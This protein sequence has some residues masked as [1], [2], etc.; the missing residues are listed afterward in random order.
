MADF[1]EERIFTFVSYGFRGGPSYDTDVSRNRVFT[2]RNANRDEPI[3]T[4]SAPYDLISVD[5][6]EDEIRDF[7]HPA[8]GRK[9]GFRFRDHKDFEFVNQQIAVGDDTT[10]QYQS[11]KTWTRGAFTTTKTIKKTNNASTKLPDDPA[12][13]ISIDAVPIASPDAAMDTTT[14]IITLAG[15]LGVG[16]VLTIDS[17][18]YD[19]P[20]FFASDF[21]PFDYA[22]FQG[23][24]STLELEEDLNA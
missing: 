11:I 12:L 2:N 6:F 20:V 14:G 7:F 21:N 5:D 13:V 8:K 4:Y 1:I 10:N 15:N 23:G 16:E 9:V 17:G 24:N 3:F 22:F 18:T 19:I